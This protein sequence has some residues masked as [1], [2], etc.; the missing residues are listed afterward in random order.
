MSVFQDIIRERLNSSEFHEQLKAAERLAHIAKQT[1]RERGERAAMRCALG[2]ASSLCDALARDI[3]NQNRGFRGR[4]TV[5][6]QELAKSV[7]IAAE[8]IWL[9]RERIKIED[10][11]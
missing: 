2:D 7:K 3:E 9:M 1:Y 4:V 11:P 10:T 5:K 6:G 8:A